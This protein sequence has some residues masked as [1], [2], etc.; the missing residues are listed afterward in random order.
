MG[1]CLALQA[2]GI[3]LA[4]NAS[5]T[6]VMAILDE[7]D[8]ERARAERGELCFGT[9]DTWV[10][11]TLSGGGAGS[12]ALHVTDA[13]NAAVTGAGRPRDASTGT[14][15]CSKQLRIPAAMLP[16]IVD[17]SGAVGAATALPGAP[18]ICGIA[19]DQQ[20]SLVG[21]GCTRRGWPR[22]PSGPAACSTSAPVRGTA[23]PSAQ[24]GRAGTFP[25]VAF[26][27]GG[28]RDLGHRGGHALG[29]HLRRVA[30]RRPRAHRVVGRVR[31]RRRGS[32]R[33]PGTSGSC[34]R[35][36]AWA[37]RSGTSAPAARWSGSP[38]GSG[39]PQI[40]RAVLEGVAHRG[41]DLVEAAEADSGYP[42][43]SLRVDGG[44]SDN[45]VFVQALADAT[46]RP[47]EISPVLEATTLGAGLLAGLALGTYCVHRR[48][49][50]DVRA[51]PH[52]RAHARRR[53]PQPPAGALA[54][55]TGQGRGDDPGALRP[56]VLT[57]HG[58]ESSVDDLPAFPGACAGRAGR[59][60]PTATNQLTADTRGGRCR[61]RSRVSPVER[62][63]FRSTGDQVPKLPL[64][65]LASQVP[66]FPPKPLSRQNQDRV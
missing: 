37:R 42:I 62:I 63:A 12:D 18:P 57:A 30:A 64:L 26:R 59:Q 50:D 38:A 35:C 39:R 48:A 6:K 49:G 32:A 53:R 11:W 33:A 10:A 14:T 58:A 44:M 17:S 2:E 28:R 16:A 41:A 25:I 20:A 43:E 4:P 52:G 40:V 65:H 23:P 36:S 56:L 19:G 60:V 21:Q 8:P 47:I 51:P 31:A 45:D 27:V 7:V 1:T 5:A 9:V 3:R 29:R 24:R 55:R 66:G 13:T 22:P 34:P 15:S 46:G 54:G 61:R